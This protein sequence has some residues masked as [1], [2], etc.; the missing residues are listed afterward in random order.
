MCWVGIFS[1][2]EP[3]D[4]SNSTSLYFIHT[5]LTH[6]AILYSKHNIHFVISLI[7]L[8]IAGRRS[9]RDR[10]RERLPPLLARVGGAIEV[11]SLICIQLA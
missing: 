4:L 6:T 1:I 9:R 11:S 3:D 10:D 8:M 5:P 2:V 7:A